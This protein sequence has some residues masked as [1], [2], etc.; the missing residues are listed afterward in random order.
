MRGGLRGTFRLFCPAVNGWKPSRGGFAAALALALTGCSTPQFPQSHAPRELFR[1]VS[2]ETGV[3]SWY[4]DKRTASMERFDGNAM[5]AAHKKLPFGTKVRVIDLKTNQSVV[6][7]IN[8]RGPYIRGRVIDLTVGAARKLG[9]YNRGICKVRL[10]VL[11]EIPILEKSNLHNRPVASA[12]PAPVSA[13]PSAKPAKPSPTPAKA[14]RPS[15]KPSPPPAQLSTPPAKPAAT[16]VKPAYKPPPRRKTAQ[17]NADVF[18]RFH[19]WN[20][21]AFS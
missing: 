17:G 9:M 8:D 16:P 10:E 13:K 19:R 15:P 7:R 5:A 11:R 12:S 20:E 21:E 18:Q 3:A 2:S 4:R 14:A 1:T 6:V